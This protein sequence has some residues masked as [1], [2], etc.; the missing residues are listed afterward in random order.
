MTYTIDVHLTPSEVRRR[1]CEDAVR[2]LQSPQ[3]S[4]PPVWFYDERGSTLFD[5]ITR[6]PEYYPT[7]SER[8]LLEAHAAEIA[9]LSKA[10]TVV[11]LGAGSCEKSR[12]L[13]D[14]FDEGGS[15][16]RYVPF[17][18]S[19]DFL[20]TAADSICDEYGGLA[21]HL[22][23]GDFHDHLSLIP[24]GGRRMIAFLGGTIGNFTPNQ[25]SKFLFDLNCIMTSDDSFLLGTDIV[26]NRDRLVA[27]YDDA[28]G[29]TAAFNKNVLSVLNE[30]LGG[31]FDPECF[32]HVALWNETEQW[33]EMRLRARTAMDVTLHAAGITVHFDEGED[34]LTEVS[35]K[36]TPAGVSEE[37]NGAGFVVDGMWGVDEGEFLLTLAHPFC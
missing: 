17:D 31:T 27:A 16:D 23:I 18:V 20:R 3:K 30:R 10:D 5:E 34:L 25:R 21:V 29:T 7:R 2:G 14:A 22:V 24:D 9:E 4:I 35:A 33:I 12:V 32:S 13:L 8:R 28:A 15:L 36:F 37:L 26:K 19:D 11:E 1:M 6:L